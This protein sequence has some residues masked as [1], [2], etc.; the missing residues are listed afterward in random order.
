MII[1]LFCFKV[2][3]V[4]ALLVQC[5]RTE[6]LTVDGCAVHRCSADYEPVCGSNQKWYGKLI[7]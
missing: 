2:M 1:Q 4:A 7:A 6:A 3:L 5:Q